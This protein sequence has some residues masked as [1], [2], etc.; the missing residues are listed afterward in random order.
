MLISILHT[1][2]RC[3][4]FANNRLSLPL[5]SSTP[6]ADVLL[7]STTVSSGAAKNFYECLTD[8]EYGPSLAPEKCPFMY[9]VRDEGFK[10]FFD[11][12]RHHV[13]QPAHKTCIAK[14]IIF[15]PMRN[16]LGCRD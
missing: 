5:V 3:D 4:I 8:P 15:S 12:I 10:D 16:R 11:Y 13:C 1:P 2:V 6:L 7:L 9:N 14:P